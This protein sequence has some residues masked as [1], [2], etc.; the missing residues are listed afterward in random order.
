MVSDS[1]GL[2]L[3]DKATRG[4]KL[5]AEEETLLQTWYDEQ[6]RAENALLNLPDN[7]NAASLQAQV[8]TT[9]AQIIT[10]TKQIEETSAENEVLRREITSLR[11]RLAVAASPS[12]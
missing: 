7:A 10:I 8:E 11:Q 12:L 4:Q 5:S 1:L 3:H 9:L 6:D 2:E